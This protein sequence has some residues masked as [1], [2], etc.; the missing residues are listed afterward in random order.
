MKTYNITIKFTA[1]KGH[2]ARVEGTVETEDGW[3]Q[4]FNGD[5]ELH[6]AIDNITERELR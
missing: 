5:A 6:R 2:M 3:V 4:P 1:T